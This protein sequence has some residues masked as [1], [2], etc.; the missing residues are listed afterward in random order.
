MQSFYDFFIQPPEM[1]GD[2]VDV[3]DGANG[4]ADDEQLQEATQRSL[5]SAPGVGACGQGAMSSTFAQSL[6]VNV[7]AEKPR[8]NLRSKGD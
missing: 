3:G 1:T 2:N 4:D 6:G 5:A 8:P 7:S